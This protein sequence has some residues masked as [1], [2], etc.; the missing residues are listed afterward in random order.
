MLELLE[1]GNQLHERRAVVVRNDGEQCVSPIGSCTLESLV[2]RTSRFQLPRD[3]SV[4]QKQR[5][6]QLITQKIKLLRICIESR[7]GIEKT[8]WR[9]AKKG[10]ICILHAEFSSER[11]I[12]YEAREEHK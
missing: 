3:S 6:E 11:H 2:R 5:A 8:T 7:F 1:S 9:I 12:G 10:I 4:S